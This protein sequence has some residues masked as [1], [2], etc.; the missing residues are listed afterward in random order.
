MA[1]NKEIRNSENL[2]EKEIFEKIKEDLSPIQENLSE[3]K[4]TVDEAKSELKKI[5]E[6]LQ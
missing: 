6:W 3:K 4:I 5:N 1:E 2:S